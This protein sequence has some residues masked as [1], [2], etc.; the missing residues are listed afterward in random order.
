[1]LQLGDVTRDLTDKLVETNAIA[2]NAFS[3]LQWEVNTTTNTM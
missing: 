2:V 1:M 3:W